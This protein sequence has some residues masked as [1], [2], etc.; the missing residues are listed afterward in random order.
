MWFIV[1][2]TTAAQAYCLVTIMLACLFWNDKM[3][4]HSLWIQSAYWQYFFNSLFFKARNAE[5]IRKTVWCQAVVSLWE[6]FIG[7]SS[8][9]PQ[10]KLIRIDSRV[11]VCIHPL[12]V[13]YLYSKFQ[14]LQLI[15]KTLAFLHV[16]SCDLTLSSSSLK[17]ILSS[18]N[19][20]NVNVAVPAPANILFIHNSECITVHAAI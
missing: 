7:F 1:S 5:H 17:P 11:N 6:E 16:L 2:Q 15:D 18:V 20:S 3:D 9:L 12:V 14:T 8:Y 13:S 4:W 19:P 10:N